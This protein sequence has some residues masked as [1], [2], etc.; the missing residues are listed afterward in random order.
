MILRDFNT[1]FD[2]PFIQQHDSLNY[3]KKCN[4]VFES[5]AKCPKCGSFILFI[6]IDR[7]MADIIIALN[8]KGYKTSQ[9]CEGHF[10]DE[11]FNPYL[12][13]HYFIEAERNEYN[14]R[15]FEAAN[16]LAAKIKE[17]KLDI[18]VVY[19]YD[20]NENNIIGALFEVSD[21][22]KD[23]YKKELEGETKL[24]YRESIKNS[25]IRDF[26]TLIESLDAFI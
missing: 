25:F 6:K 21:N 2:Y 7:G 23:N 26:N 1:L 8:A 10:E 22:Y 11:Y 5:K 16:V 17:L 19:L 4:E 3:C 9:C 12:Y 18:D 14:Q 24:E 15:R 13:F 20:K